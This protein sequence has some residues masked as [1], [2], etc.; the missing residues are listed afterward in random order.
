MTSKA[1]ILVGVLGAQLLGMGVS[2]AALIDR[3]GGLIYD[4]VLDVTWMQNANYA[5]THFSFAGAQSYVDNLSYYDSVRGVTW[6]DWRLPTA[7]NDISSWG[8]DPTGQ[9]SELSYMYYI[10][11]GFA[12]EYSLDR[13]VPAPTSDAY[14]PFVNL[15]YR[16][17]W[18]G[19]QT[20]WNPEHVWGL[21]FHFGILDRADAG[22][23]L[24]VWA[25]RDGDV[26]AAAASVPEPGTLALFGLGLGFLGIQRRK[27]QAA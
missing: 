3:G 27:R 19:T 8:W 15:Q 25:L 23:T 13:W 21:H 7:V 12:P 24:Y 5:D 26:G 1:K 2:Q 10:N 9:N 22:D 11:L 4:D 16:G 6:D 14:N 20:W 17:Y 18:T